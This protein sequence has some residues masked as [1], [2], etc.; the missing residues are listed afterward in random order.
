[1]ASKLFYEFLSLSPIQRLDDKEIAKK[2]ALI[3]VDYI[4]SVC[5]YSKDE[6]WFEVE[7]EINK[8]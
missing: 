6:Y 1:M 4:L 5:D 8:I 3:V 2:S 7:N